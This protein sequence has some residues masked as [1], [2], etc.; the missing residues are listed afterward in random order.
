VHPAFSRTISLLLIAGVAY[1]AARTIKDLVRIQ[2]MVT[3][4]TP[5]HM[6]AAGGPFQL[7]FRAEY[8]R[9]AQRDVFISLKQTVTPE[10]K[11]ADS[12][13]LPLRLVGTSQSRFGNPI[14][15]VEDETSHV[16]G[17]YSLGDHIPRAGQ[18]TAIARDRIL[19][20]HDGQNVTLTMNLSIRETGAR[21]SDRPAA[22]L[23]ANLAPS[24]H[25]GRD[26]RH[27]YRHRRSRRAKK[28]RRIERIG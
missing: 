16:Q 22:R 7:F 25:Q 14:A 17:L 3:S 4:S 26:C 5:P 1:F 19:I 24:H 10:P 18:L 13:N 12:G 20:N 8:G 9:I 21:L 15:I 23:T 11:Q 28:G 27:R 2:L 6:T